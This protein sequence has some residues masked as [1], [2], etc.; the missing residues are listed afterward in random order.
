[1]DGK[2]F[3]LAII[4]GYVYTIAAGFQLYYLWISL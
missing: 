1:M 4:G 3:N 2:L